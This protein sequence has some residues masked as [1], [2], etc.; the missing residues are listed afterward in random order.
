MISDRLFYEK[1]PIV[2][3]RTLE[4]LAVLT[5]PSA[6]SPDDENTRTTMSTALTR[7]L[8]R[9][10]DDGCRLLPCDFPREIRK[11]RISGIVS[12]DTDTTRE[13]V[14]VALP[15]RIRG[16]SNFNYRVE[17]LSDHGAPPR[18]RRIAAAHVALP[19]ASRHFSARLQ[20][21]DSSFLNPVSHLVDA[22][23]GSLARTA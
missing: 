4:T 19:R 23:S 21:V 6:P 5:V 9:F 12:P 18:A 2:H 3:R 16:V 11:I 20:V 1:S 8:S 15:R 13:D 22:R 14:E 17:P 7:L 10:G